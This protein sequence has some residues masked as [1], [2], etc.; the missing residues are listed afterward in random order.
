[1]S[2][3]EEF[4]N[5]LNNSEC[6]LVFMQQQQKTHSYHQGSRLHLVRKIRWSRLPGWWLWHHSLQQG[7][8]QYQHII[9]ILD[10]SKILDWEQELIHAKYA[11]RKVR[12]VFK[13]LNL[14]AHL[15]VFMQQQQRQQQRHNSLQQG[16]QVKKRQIRMGMG[17]NHQQYLRAKEQSL[18]IQKLYPEVKW[19]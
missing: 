4:L 17:I 16:S 14:N 15:F 9:H 10:N 7:S 13:N 3:K 12:G 18:Q 8:N 5:I 1:M 19:Q 2:E 11:I 6:S